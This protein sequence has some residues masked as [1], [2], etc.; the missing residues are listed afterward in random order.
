M[1]WGVKGKRGGE[2]GRLTVSWFYMTGLAIAAINFETCF[3]RRGEITC[4]INFG[5]KNDFFFK[6]RKIG[7][8]GGKRTSIRNR[9]RTIT[10]CHL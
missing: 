8:K 5:G 9:K 6:V 3:P 10:F 1:G 2:G 4:L 7:K